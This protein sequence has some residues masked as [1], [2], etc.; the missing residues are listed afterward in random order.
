MKEVCV[1]ESV[2]DFVDLLS[3]SPEVAEY[4]G[5]K[6][7]VSMKDLESGLYGEIDGKQIYMRCDYRDLEV[8]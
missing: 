6:P 1:I 4:R 3:L 5:F 8:I 2:K 7:S